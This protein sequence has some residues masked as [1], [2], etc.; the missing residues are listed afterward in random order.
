MD[1]C[2]SPK[3]C[4]SS[5][6][7]PILCIRIQFV[8]QTI[9]HKQYRYRWRCGCCSS[10]DWLVLGNEFH[11]LA[12]NHPLPCHISMDPP[13][14]WALAIRYK[15]D[16]SNAEVPML[17]VIEG[18]KVTGYQ[19]FFM[20]FKYGLRLLFC[21]SSRY[22]SCLLD[23]CNSNGGNFTLFS[24]QVM[25]NPTKKSAMRLFGFSISYITILFSLMAVDQL[26]RSGF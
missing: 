14:F 13:H 10:I 16:Y 25:I 7:L 6:S 8:A 23:N 2:K 15:D 26:V 21:S 18:T 12:T 11:R 17:P 4:S 1:I 9:L 5:F 19:W 22:G 20:P 3:R 24:F